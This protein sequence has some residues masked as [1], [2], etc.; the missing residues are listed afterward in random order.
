MVALGY[1]GVFVAILYGILPV[2]MV[3]HGRYIEKKKQAFRVFGGKAL[4]LIIFTGA[5]GIIFIQ[6]AVNQK[7][8]ASL[9]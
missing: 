9:G 4:L 8:V 5:I 3:W 6:V 7:W 1:A 2:L